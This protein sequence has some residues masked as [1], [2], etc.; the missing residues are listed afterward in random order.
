MQPKCDISEPE[1]SF[2]IKVEDVEKVLGKNYNEKGSADK[3]V[4]RLKQILDKM[5]DE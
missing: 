3:A 5:K 4:K 2:D 1:V